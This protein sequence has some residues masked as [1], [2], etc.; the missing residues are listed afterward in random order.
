MHHMRAASVGVRIV[1]VDWHLGTR[2]FRRPVMGLACQ[3]DAR[4][5]GEHEHVRIIMGRA[6]FGSCDTPGVDQQLPSLLEKHICEHLHRNR[7]PVSFV[8]ADV[9]LRMRTMQMDPH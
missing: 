6:G 4:R 7:A 1:E 2:S 3:A 5:Y 8:R 9:C